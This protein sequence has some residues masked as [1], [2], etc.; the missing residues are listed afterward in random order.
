M[1]QQ[2]CQQSSCSCHCRNRSRNVN[3]AFSHMTKRVCAVSNLHFRGMLVQRR[4]PML[5]NVAFE[6]YG[7]VQ[8]PQ[9]CRSFYAALLHVVSLPSLATSG[10]PPWSKP[11][12]PISRCGHLFGF[13]HRRQRSKLRCSNDPNP[14][15]DPPSEDSPVDITQN[16]PETEVRYLSK[17]C[18]FF[19]FV[20]FSWLNIV[21][22]MNKAIPGHCRY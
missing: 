6:L 15:E 8:V 4:Y 19:S 13:V 5:W 17:S 16:G 12:P 18:C 7:L 14:S 10:L 22:V 20:Y 11:L 2:L 1:A 9:K 3:F 21:V